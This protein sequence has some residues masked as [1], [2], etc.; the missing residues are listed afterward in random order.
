MTSQTSLL[1]WRLERSQPQQAEAATSERPT[2]CYTR[3]TGGKSRAL[4]FVF[5]TPS[6]KL[7]LREAPKVWAVSAPFSKQARATILVLR[8]FCQW[9]APSP[10]SK[11]VLV[12]KSG[13]HLGNQ[14]NFSEAVHAT[15]QAAG[16]RLN[17]CETTVCQH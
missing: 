9:L 11:K 8:E 15:S 12:L 4:R 16:L 1:S 14:E 7:P 10:H 17:V 2:M 5:K 3:T 6:V 13:L